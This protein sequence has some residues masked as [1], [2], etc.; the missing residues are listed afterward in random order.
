[1]WNKKSATCFICENDL[2]DLFQTTNQSGQPQT[3]TVTVTGNQNNNG[4]NNSGTKII[5]TLNSVQTS[6]NNPSNPTII[7]PTQGGQQFIVT[8][9]T[10]IDDTYPIHCSENLESFGII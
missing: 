6:A 10:F 1:M 2:F 8:S 7:Q 3:V 5:Q 4:T 9:K